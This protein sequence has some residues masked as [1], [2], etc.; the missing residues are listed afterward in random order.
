MLKFKLAVCFIF[1]LLVAQA[2]EPKLHPTS[3]A[4]SNTLKLIMAL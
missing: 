1:D 2:R 3:P 4:P